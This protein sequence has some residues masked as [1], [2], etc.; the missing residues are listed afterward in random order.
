MQQPNL[1]EIDAQTLQQKLRAGEVVLI[2]VREPH[3]FAAERIPGSV[4]M[5]LS[6]FDP[7][8]A[9]AQAE[10]KPLVISC[11]MG[12]RATHAA[13]A[14]VAAGKPAPIVFK[15]SLNGWKQ[16]GLPTEAGPARS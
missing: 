9:A 6:A 10:G 3:E 16:A 8:A 1:S 11:Q 13:E 5:P 4:S 2:D 12:G 14:M 15:G 7:Q